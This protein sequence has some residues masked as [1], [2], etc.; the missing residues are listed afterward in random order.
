MCAR[1]GIESCDGVFAAHGINL[2]ARFVLATFVRLL[3]RNEAT[4]AMENALRDALPTVA[5]CGSI[6]TD[7]RALAA[8]I[9][10]ARDGS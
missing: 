3:P 6:Q 9:Q 10:P 7:H 8:V 5:M 2:T 1:S 4:R